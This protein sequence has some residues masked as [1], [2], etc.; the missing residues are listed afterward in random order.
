MGG[1]TFTLAATV[2]DAV[3]LP[4]LIWRYQSLH[5]TRSGP[6]VFVAPIIL[7]NP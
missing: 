3:T 7:I 6:R 5:H 4:G 2:T 1:R